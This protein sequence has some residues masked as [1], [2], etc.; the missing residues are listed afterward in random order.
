MGAPPDFYL[1]LHIGR[2][3]EFIEFEVNADGELRYI[4]KTQYRGDS[5][6][7]RKRLFLSPTVMAEIARIVEASQVMEQDDA[8]WPPPD[9]DGRQELEVRMGGGGGAGGAAGGGEGA[10]GDGAADP[11]PPTTTAATTHVSLATTKLASTVQ[12]ARC[13]DAAGL[14]RY[15]FLCQDLKAMFL[16]LVAAH[17]QVQ[18]I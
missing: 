15:Y 16:A 1:R 6:A 13:A 12:I 2:A 10:G 14:K 5:E 9:K 18:P 7:I 11:P 3:T 8:A 17:F 4:N